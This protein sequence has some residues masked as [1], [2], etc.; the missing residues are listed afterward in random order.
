MERFAMRIGEE[1]VQGKVAF[2]PLVPPRILFCR[3]GRAR[4][5]PGLAALLF[6]LAAA[7]AG[8]A[9]LVERPGEWVP[10][11]IR[12][13]N[14]KGDEVP[15]ASLLDRPVVLSL[16]YYSC[17]H[18]CPQVLAALS[19]MA[20][21]LPLD[22]GVDYRLVTWSF[23]EKDGPKDAAE[24]KRNYLRPL[25]ASFPR[26]SWAFLTASAADTRKLTAAL[27]FSFEK[28]E[29][30]FVH[31]SI[32]VILGPGGRISRYIHV[33]DY[34]Y[35]A[36]SPPVFQP[37]EIAAA[38]RDASRGAVANVA[39]APLLF[40]FPHRPEGW[41]GYYG[42]TALAGGGTLAGLLVLFLYLAAGRRGGKRRVSR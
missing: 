38:L 3:H 30:G 24:A 37:V 15:L 9:G 19:R 12:C 27:G 4:S 26:E 10:G 18:I 6:L 39:R 22:P 7:V 14:D 17:E 36:P 33:S 1:D 16:V 35:G 34:A 20:Q 23:D 8:P 5:L 41:G 40:C 21:D 13:V 31:P 42:L 29:H 11:N 2:E 28:A 25:P 32:L